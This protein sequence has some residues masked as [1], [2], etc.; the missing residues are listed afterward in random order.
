MSTVKEESRRELEVM[1]REG[2]EDKRMIE[3][4]KKV[5]DS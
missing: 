2:I 5:R 3:R 1:R 4:L